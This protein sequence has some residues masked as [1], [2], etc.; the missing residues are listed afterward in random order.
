MGDKICAMVGMGNSLRKTCSP[1]DMPSFQTVYTWFRLYPELL[2]Q[3]MRAKDDSADSDHDKLDEISEG[4][5]DGTYD[6]QSARVAADIIKWSA[7]KKKPKKYGDRQQI[8]H[9]G[10]IGLMD[11]TDVELKAKLDSLND[12]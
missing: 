7:G 2:E 3:Y 1:A 10:K 8:E 6:P 4:V 9:T 5:L 11:L 12:E